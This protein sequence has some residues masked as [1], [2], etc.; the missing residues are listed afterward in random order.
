MSKMVT[1]LE[2]RFLLALW[3]L[4]GADIRKGLVNSRFSGKTAVATAACTSLIEAGAINNSADSRFLTL[5]ERGKV[6]LASSLAEDKFEFEAQIGAKTA[7]ALL[8]WFRSKAAVNQ[9]SLTNN[10][11]GAA[12]TTYSEFKEMALSSYDRLNSEFNFDRLVPIYR[13]RR[14][15]GDRVSRTSFNEW[16]LKMQADGILQLLE[17]TVEDSAPDKLEDS[18]MTKVSGL[19]CYAKRL[20]T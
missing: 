6:L 1:N 7:N 13:M 11:Q 2:V 14:D 20:Y 18:V 3:D 19:R 12:I 5:T 17:G 4:G 15:L 8:K 9:Q 10:R 16:L